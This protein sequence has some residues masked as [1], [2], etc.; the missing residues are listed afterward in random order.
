MW[1]QNYGGV[2]STGYSA[3]INNL[4]LS[5]N[6][7]IFIYTDPAYSKVEVWYSGTQWADP[8]LTPGWTLGFVINGGIEAGESFS[9][10]VSVAL[11]GEGYRIALGVVLGDFKNVANCGRVYIYDRR[12]N[13]GNW[14]AHSSLFTTIPVT[15]EKAG[16]T[17]SLST[18]GL[19]LAFGALQKI[20]VFKATS[21]NLGVYYS[22]IISITYPSNSFGALVKISG[23]GETV[24]SAVAT[25]TANNTGLLKIFKIRDTIYSEL[26]SITGVSSEYLGTQFQISRDGNTIAACGLFSNTGVKLYRYTGTGWVLATLLAGTVGYI[27]SVIALSGDADTLAWSLPGNDPFAISAPTDVEITRVYKIEPF[28]NTQDPITFKD[29]EFMGSIKLLALNR[30]PYDN[31]SISLHEAFSR[32]KLQGRGFI[33]FGADTPKSDV[34]SGT[35]GYNT[36]GSGLSIVGGN[37]GTFG[38]PYGYGARWVRLFDFLFIHGAGAHGYGPVV[39]SIAG[40]NNNGDQYVSSL[41]LA[42]SYIEAQRYY[43]GPGHDVGGNVGAIGWNFFYSDIRIKFDITEPIINNACDY[44]E[45]IEFKSYKWDKSIDVD[46]TQ[47]ELGVIAQQLETV[48]PKFINKSDDPKKH[49]IINTNVFSTFMMKSIQELIF[50]NKKLKADIVEMKNDIQELKKNVELL[51]NLVKITP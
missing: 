40:A 35:I 1:D 25:G 44:V 47:C 28:I 22:Q 24:V 45:K 49:K 2:L 37:Y 11:S 19:T 14:T 7:K 38:N 12:E 16:Q 33:E 30:S 20:L 34:A 48:Y 8:S 10:G 26:P 27:Q 17:V 43:I 3:N 6:G 13:S 46:E 15:N 18:N 42:G 51:L 9:G 29:S 31:T 32:L 50:E 21:M 39:V 36:W 23:D 5:Y 41:R 4:A